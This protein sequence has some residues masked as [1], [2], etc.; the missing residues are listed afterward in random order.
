[1]KAL[2]TGASGFIGSHLVDHLLALGYSVRVLLRKSSRLEW[3]SNLSLEVIYGDLFNE[4]ALAEAV[5]GVDCIYHSAGVTKAKTP[6]AYFQANTKGTTNL[7]AATAQ[8][9]RQLKRFVHISS[10]AAAGPSPTNIPIDEMAPPNPLTTYGKSKWAAELECHSF[11]NVLPITIIRPPVVF[12]PRDRDVL[13][14]FR[15]V[16]KGL[17]PIVGFSERYVS[18]VHVTDLVRGSVLAG[19]SPRA[20]GQTYFIS[21]KTGYGWKEIGD[22]T[23]KIIGRRVFRVRIPPPLVFAIASVGEIIARFSGKPALVNLEKARDM[24]QDYWTCDSSKALRDLGYEQTLTLEEGIR[25]TVEWY[26]SHGWL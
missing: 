21:S 24:V 3:L 11:S 5:S 12:G 14:F 25:N 8:R 16:N 9:N 13:E 4:Q 1:V 6:E 22:I 2:V 19:E 10:Q 17:Q 26:R 18:L 20:V 15:T 7:L 23:A